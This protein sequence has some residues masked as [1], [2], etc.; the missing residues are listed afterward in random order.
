MHVLDEQL[1][2]PLFFATLK[3][4]VSCCELILEALADPCRDDRNGQC[5]LGWAQEGAR[6]ILDHISNGHGSGGRPHIMKLLQR[7]VLERFQE[8]LPRSLDAILEKADGLSN[9]A[10]GHR[11]HDRTINVSEDYA[12]AGQERAVHYEEARGAENSTLDAL[13]RIVNRYVTLAGVEP[14]DLAKILTQ[15]RMRRIALH[16]SDPLVTPRHD[17]VHATTCTGAL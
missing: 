16:G 4:S 13:R 1:R 3:D 7:H 14:E 2:S 12:E 8:L 5:V 17:G 6:P 11:A 9:E 10:F 15:W